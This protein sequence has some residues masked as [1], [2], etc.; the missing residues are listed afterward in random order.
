PEVRRRARELVRIHGVLEASKAKAHRE[1]PTKFDAYAAF[2][3]PLKRLPSHRLLAIQRGKA[4]GVLKIKI[5]VETEPFERW[6]LSQTDGGRGQRNSAWTESLLAMVLYAVARLILPGAET[7]V[8]TE[9]VEQ[10][11]QEAIA[12][13]TSNLKQLLLSP[14]LGGMLVLG[15]LPGQ[16]TGCESVVL[17]EA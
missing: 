13:C 12:V 10:A 4:E 5:E 3:E 14:P 17:S 6:A 11:H 9:R 7:Q 1:S 8:E 2:R 16:R 15:V